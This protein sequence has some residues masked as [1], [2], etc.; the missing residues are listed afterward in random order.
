MRLDRAR[1][2]GA[3]ESIRKSNSRTNFSVSRTQRFKAHKWP[4]LLHL[5]RDLFGQRFR[6]TS[7]GG[8]GT[9]RKH[10][11]VVTV[12]GHLART[13]FTAQHAQ[14]E[15]KLSIRNVGELLRNLSRCEQILSFAKLD[16]RPTQRQGIIEPL[17]DLH[18]KPAVDTAINKL[19]REVEH[20][21]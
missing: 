15:N 7:C 1:L 18:V 2:P 3:V 11:V 12:Q 6:H 19:N 21:E 13:A 9:R 14:L 16:R 4:I 5:Q 20:D 8:V 17:F 10:P